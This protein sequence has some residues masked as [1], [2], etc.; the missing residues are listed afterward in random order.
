MPSRLWVLAVLS[1][2]PVGSQD[3]SQVC[4]HENAENVASSIEIKDGET[5]YRD[6][7]PNQTHRYFHRNFN[8][9]TMNQPDEYRK[10]IINLE[11]CRGVV[12]LFV[13]KTR[14]CYPNP[15]SCIDLDPGGLGRRPSECKW[16]HFMS[17]IDGSRDGTPTFFE[18]P[19]SSTKYFISVYATENSAYTL[20]LLA[21]IGAYPRPGGMGKLTARQL[22]E[23]Q[24]QISWQEA[25]YKPV[26]I[27]STNQYWV[28]SSML[29]E[30]D[31]RTNMAVFLRPDKI[32][33]TVC[34]LKNNTDRHYDRVPAAECGSGFCNATIDGVVTDRRYVFNVVVESDRG[35]LMAYAGIVMRTDWEI[36][37]QATSDRTLQVV[38]AVSGS[39][40]AMVVIIY[41]LMLKLYG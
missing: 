1:I 36:V 38:G 32:M 29:L 28:Y 3:L 14:R 30:N 5:V 34:G 19:L 12:Y 22:R 11:P 35:F 21:D 7:K 17:E 26:G 24:V 9:T 31:N 23:L 18:V 20:T 39:V 2:V 25:E 16:T 13:R 37:R 8:V 27:T 33:N 40:L 15:Y 6:I 10:L 4:F 41:F